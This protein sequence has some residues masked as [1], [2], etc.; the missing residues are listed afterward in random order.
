MSLRRTVT[1][2]AVVLMLAVASGAS[3]ACVPMGYCPYF[4]C[5]GWFNWI[6]NQSFY[7]GSSCW[8]LY[9]AATIKNDGQMCTST[10]YVNFGLGL[11]SGLQQVVHIAKAGEPYYDPNL[12][13]SHFKFDYRVQLVDP[14]HSS[15]NTL[16]IGLY[17][18]QTGALLQWINTLTGAQSS[19]N[20]VMTLDFNNPNLVGKDVR[21]DIQA[22]NTNSD[23]KIGI[24]GMALWQVPR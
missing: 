10:P 1:A 6:S 14:H 16:T 20:C 18:N 7:D 21:I 22:R 9:G 2:V 11:S 12:S 24:T 23:T 13:P 8:T 15:W 19:P 5:I 3:A 4:G 17:D